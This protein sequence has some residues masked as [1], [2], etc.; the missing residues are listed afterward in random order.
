MQRTTPRPRGAVEWPT[1]VLILL[2]YAAWGG[3]TAWAG[4]LGLW[5]AFPAIVLTTSLHASLT[6]EVVHGHPTRWRAV[7]HL[8]VAP[9]ISLF[10]PHQRYE[11]THL[12]HH[13]DP[14]LTD[15]YDD[16]E[17]NYLA[18]P[19]WTRL[20]GPVRVLMRANNTLFGRML[21]GP[22]ISF[23]CFYVSDLRLILSG[24]RAVLRAWLLHL[25][26]LAAVA[27]W[28]G[29]AGEVSAGLY[30]AAAYGGASLQKIRSYLEHRAHPQARG[31]TAIVED[32]GP[33]ALL[34]LNNN[35]HAVHHAH[36]AVPWY[37]L[38]ALYRGRRDH[39]LRRNHG[40][41]YAGYGA[42]FR[43]FLFRTKDPVP[44]PLMPATAAEPKEPA[45]TAAVASSAA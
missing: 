35:L 36:P 38:P 17:S 26:C 40:Y 24:D 25:P 41:R 8:M 7:N 32:R 4:H 21:L 15:P 42:I 5:I 12:A 16:P 30:L 23:T 3:A 1:A 9:A 39:F 44:H 29:A 34:F 10:V 11:A 2:A 31:R 33:L 45:S 13:H 20:A 22:A 37:H 27:I 28:L 18:P 43:A 6:H 14:S 19:I